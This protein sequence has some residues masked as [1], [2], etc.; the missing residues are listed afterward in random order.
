MRTL[1]VLSLIAAWMPLVSV[2]AQAPR[3]AALQ[4]GFGEADI[5][6]S[7]G[8]DAKPVF[9]AGFGQ[10]RKATGVHDPIMARAAVL[11]DGKRKIALVSV[12]LIGLSLEVVDRARAQL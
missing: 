3:E 12:D 1:V 8:K 5:T 9:L 6:P 7:V 11:A 10:N 4:A 2:S